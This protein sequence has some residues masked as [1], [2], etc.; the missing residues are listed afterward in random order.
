MRRMDVL[1]LLTFVWPQVQAL[2]PRH[3]AKL[4]IVGAGDPL[5]RGAQAGHDSIYLHSRPPLVS[6][7]GSSPLLR[8]LVQALARVNDHDRSDW[9]SEGLTEYYAIELLRRAGGLVMSAIRPSMTGSP[10]T[11]RASP[12]CAANRS[13]P[14]QWP[15]RCCYCRNWTARFA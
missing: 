2:V 7:R 11:A 9:I 6:E 3:P 12:P 10:A 4:L 5:W 13:A 15:R 14:G 8:E 1:T